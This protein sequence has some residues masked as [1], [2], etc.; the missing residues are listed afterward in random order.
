MYFD[1][2]FPVWA[3]VLVVLCTASALLWSVLRL[4]AWI[5]A[6]YRITLGILRGAALLAL[7]ISFTLLLGLA[8]I[9]KLPSWF[10]AGYAVG[11]GESF[12]I[13]QLFIFVLCAS[14]IVP[15]TLL[16]GILFPLV[17]VIWTSVQGLGGRARSRSTSIAPAFYAPPATPF[18]SPS[19]M[20][21]LPSVGSTVSTIS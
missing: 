14:V 21:T 12:P 13:F 15:S 4:Q 19:S 8:V 17:A 16:M 5:P 11:F 6:R 20:M 7:L 2:P 9:G 18:I 3:V 10:L 1:F